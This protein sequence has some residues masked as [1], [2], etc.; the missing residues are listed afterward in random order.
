MLPTVV[1]SVLRDLRRFVLPALAVL[2][3]VACVSGSLLYTQSLA[4]GAARLQQASRPDVS[5]EVRPA[6]DGAP[7]GEAVRQRLASLPGVASA[8]GTLR[9]RAFLVARDGT[10]VG[11]PSADVGV[12]FVPDGHGADPRCPM[13]EGRGPHGPGEVA[14]DRLAARRAGHRVGDRVRIVVAGEVRAVRLT[15]VFTVYDPA[16]T[17]AGT[18]TAFDM[19][20]A[21]ALFAPAPGRYASVTLTT[22]PGTSSAALAKRVA[23]VLPHGLE[24]VTRARLDAEAAAAPDRKKLGTLLLLFA[25]IALFV[26]AFLVSNTFTM[27]ST[28]RAR[29]HALLRAVGASRGQV[30]R[31]VLAEA[32]LVGA[33]AAVAGYALGVGVAAALAA[34]FGPAAGPAGA[35][36][37]DVLSPL[38][39]LAALGVG[40]GF[41][42][43]AAYVPALRASAVA[44]V[45]ALRTDVPVPAVA[46][47]RRGLLGL[48]VTV[49]GALLLAAGEG[50]LAVLSLA[51]PVLLVGLILLI[52]QFARAVTHVLRAPVR[53]LAGARGTLALA[54]ARRNPRRTAATAGA[55]TVCVALVSAVTVALS[56]LSAT[57]G[58]EAVAALPTD[59]RISAVDF[60]EIGA[61]TAGR[62][63]RLPHVTA[64][65]A[66]REAGFRLSDGGDLWAV[67]V[68]PVAVGRGRLADL[69]VRSGDLD[70]LSHGIAVTRKLA[71]EHGW[72]VGDRV[73]GEELSDAGVPDSRALDREVVA[74]YDGPEALGPALLPESAVAGGGAV[75]SVL[76]RAEPGHT[77]D[78][79]KEIRRA[80]RNPVLVVQDR[81]DV[82]RDAERGFGS[83]LSVLYAML[84]VTAAVAA[85][86]VANTMGMAVFER[87]REIGLLRAVGLDRAGVRSMLRLESVVVSALGAGLGIVAGGAAGVAA[88]AGQAGAVISVPWTSLVALLVGASVV[89]VLAAL[90]PA[91]RASAIPVPRAVGGEVG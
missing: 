19:R 78:L 77:T 72:R 63:A 21:R 17:A 26:S 42:T 51:T 68:D 37:L 18:V 45:A 87:A 5:V 44:P 38:P 74:V 83:L 32:A 29:E 81:A 40:V 31:T 1:R 27:L 48:A 62:V 13:T 2:I 53:R 69:T 80:L 61:G 33:G 59:L 64:V 54:N 90:G 3:G 60:A 34:L 22:A 91:A 55:V 15:G 56:S 79:K 10:L 76:V 8:R 28:A 82:G 65:S 46:Q 4:R 88:V 12:G 25:G 70:G 66:V 50:D 16:T 14:V 35:A 36:P 47:G 85:L 20:T 43:A 57:A 75:I 86:G 23:R 41:T 73:T 9:G 52:P 39:L 7:P 67:A 84:S 6:G 24:A 71:A 30:L 58:R 89:G 49:A 11:P